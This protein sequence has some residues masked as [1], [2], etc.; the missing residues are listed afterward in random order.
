MR[1]LHARRMLFALG[2]V[3]LL[4]LTGCEY[5]A[6]TDS[7]LVKNRM[8]E[9]CLAV[10]ARDWG[11]TAAYFDAS[12]QWQQGHNKALQGRDAA[13][14]FTTTLS[15]MHQMDDFFIIVDDI[16]KIKP[17]LIEA[18]VTMQAHLVLSSTEMNYSNCFWTARMGWVKRG[19]GKWLI[20]YIIETSPR[21]E[22]KFS[23]I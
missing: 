3:A 22:G 10:T 20:S 21:K 5:L 14:G 8:R 12:V 13:R 9:Y 6:L 17:D 15:A 18:K 2:A 16:T 23:R 7:Q 19:P 4:G 11:A 1:R